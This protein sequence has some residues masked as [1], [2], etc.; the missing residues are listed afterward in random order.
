MS[1]K[2]YTHG[3]VVE[4]VNQVMAEE[5]ELDPAK[6]V[7]EARLGEDLEL[8]SLDGVDVVVA[9]EKAFTCRL[10]E[11]QARSLRTLGDIHTVVLERLGQVD[12]VEGAA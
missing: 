6:L 11:Q 2:R 1:D 3:E 7:P 4:I 12:R 10:G 8:D 5:F 9:I